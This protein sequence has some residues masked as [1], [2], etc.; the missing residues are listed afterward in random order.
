M[1]VCVCVGVCVCV[2]VCVFEALAYCVQEDCLTRA[3]RCY[4]GQTSGPAAISAAIW[5][6]SH[7]SGCEEGT[8]IHGG[9]AISRGR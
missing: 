5:Q 9:A 4:S 6:A 2:C 7:Q 1:C 3:H 8:Q